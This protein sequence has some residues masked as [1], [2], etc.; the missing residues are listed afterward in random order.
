MGATAFIL[1]IP[2]ALSKGAN[3]TLTVFGFYETMDFAWGGIGMVVV[4]L[5][6]SIFTGWVWGTENAVKEISLGYQP[7][8]KIAPIW[9]LIIK[10]VAPVVI[11]IILIG[12]FI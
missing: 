9:S 4:G 6:L 12:L 5:T 1:A 7:F 8:S 2:S 3:E 10:W 11:T